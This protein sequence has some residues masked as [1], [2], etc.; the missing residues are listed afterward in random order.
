MLD[1]HNAFGEVHHNL[2]DCVLEHHHV[3]QD[4]REIVKNLY[5]CFKTSMFTGSFVTNFILMEKGVLQG[6]C[7]SPLVF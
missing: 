3:P 6:H 5:Y 1:L 7:Y 4:I 2:I